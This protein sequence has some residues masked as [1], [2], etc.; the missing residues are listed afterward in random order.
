[1][2]Q[3]RRAETAREDADRIDTLA[4]LRASQALSSQT[5]LSR[6][7]AT[8]VDQ[9]TALTGATDV[10]LVLHDDDRDGW[11]VLTSDSGDRIPIE[12]A[13]ARGEV[14]VTAFRFVSRTGTTLVS[15]DAARDDRFAADPYVAARGH[16]S[17][18]A[19]AIRHQG[20]MRAVLMLVNDRSRHMFT[21]Q[22]MDAVQLI[23]G[24]LAVSL[25]NALLYA[26]L[27]ARVTERTVAL[28]AA[29][30]QLEQMSRTDELTQ[31]A[32]RRRFDQVLASEWERALSRGGPLGVLL[33]DVDSFKRY[34]DHYGHVA[35][36]DCLRRVAAALADCVRGTDLVCR[37]GGEEFAVILPG[38]GVEVLHRV[39]ER[40]RAAVSTLGIPHVESGAGHVTVSVGAASTVPAPPSTVDELVARADGALYEAKRSGRDQVHVAP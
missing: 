24:Q 16:C 1:V 4:I 5:S 31:L 18:L 17:L 10:L 37:Y 15:P 35:G 28:A 9:L 19:V 38:A 3:T 34:N 8:I 12:E 40:F 32:N 2:L 14:P 6:L 20:T 36:D 11:F 29:N 27:E 21:S 33:L 7:R 26:S 23:A 25:T 22:R 39:G 30:R 13:G